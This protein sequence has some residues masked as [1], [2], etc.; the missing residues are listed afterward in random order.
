MR[1]GHHLDVLDAV[2]GRPQPVR[3]QPLGG[4]GVAGD[5]GV[6]RA[7]ADRMEAGLQAGLG[8]RDDVVADRRGVEVAV[9]GVRCVGVRVAQAMRCAS[10]S[11]RRRTGRRRLPVRPAPWPG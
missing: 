8:A 10:R 9:A 4:L 11:S 5:D 1:R 3:A 6:Q 7:V 2:P